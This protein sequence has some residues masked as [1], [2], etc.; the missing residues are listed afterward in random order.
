MSLILKVFMGSV[1]TNEIE[2]LNKSQHMNLGNHVGKT[3]ICALQNLW[4]LQ[5]AYYT[6]F[7]LMVIMH[8]KETNNCMSM[9]K[10]SIS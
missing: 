2:K 10:Y 5:T 4:F 9:G 1:S 7:K 8:A 3:R 6:N